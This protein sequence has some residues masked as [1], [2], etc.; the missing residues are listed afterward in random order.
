MNIESIN[1]AA[2]F[3]E[4][5]PVTEALKAEIAEDMKKNGFDASKPL[6]IWQGK[7]LLID[8]H[9]RLLAAKEVGIQEV[10]V[11]ERDFA[12]EDEAVEY[13]IRC[14]K[15]RRNLEDKDIFQCIVVLDK[16]KDKIANL[17]QG[18]SEAQSCASGKTSSETASVLGISAR[19]VEQARTVWDKAPDELKEAVRMGDMSINAAYNKTVKPDNGSPESLELAA[20]E[21]EK[22]DSV[23]GIIK[24]R[25]T[26]EQIRELIKR[27]KSEI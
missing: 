2:P 23:I 18:D 9:T 14:Q 6:V 7:N 25:L 3:C 17:K 4:L 16:R 11:N 13:A 5:F 26:P 15:N 27:L 8:G 10:T 1:T 24:E 19:K 12:D 21:I 20:E 22:I